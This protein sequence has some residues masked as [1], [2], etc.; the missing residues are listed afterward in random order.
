MLKAR[1]YD[2]LPGEGSVVLALDSLTGLSIAVL[3]LLLGIAAQRW[4]LPFALW[5][6]LLAPL[7]L[8]ALLPHGEPS[9]L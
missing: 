7:A 3:P 6:L 9:R 8:L 1:L 4:G 5:L 2:T